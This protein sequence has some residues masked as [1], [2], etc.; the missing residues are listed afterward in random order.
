MKLTL[1]QKILAG[2]VA[3][4]AILITVAVFSFKNSEKYIDSAEWVNHT[5]Q[6]LIEF[7]QILINTVDA[8]TGARGYVI[9]GDESYLE[10][11]RTAEANV[12]EHLQNAKDLTKDNPKQQQNIEKLTTRINLRVEALKKCVTLR[13]ENFEAAQKFISSGEG[14]M[15]QDEIRKTIKEASDLEY[16]LLDERDKTSKS[17]I[18]NFNSLFIFLLLVI[19]LVLISVYIIIITNLRALKKAEDETAQKNWVLT[20]SGDLVKEMQG[21]KNVKELTQVVVEHLAQYLNAQVAAVYVTNEARD[22]LTLSGG[23]AMNMQHHDHPG[24]SYGQGLAG[25]AAAQ[26]KTIIVSDVAKELFTA[27]S[28]FG[29]IRPKTIIAV[30]FSYERSVVGVVELGNVT[31]FSEIQKQ[32]MEQ[33]ADSIAIAITSAQSREKTKELLEE[34]Q[35]QAE[36]LQAQQE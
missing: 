20:G 1:S 35:R 4:T 17:D 29:N 36:D 5:H 21:N 28:S 25:Q 6:V 3:C 31:H 9:T 26:N 14:K 24:F 11:Y 7:D 23:Y 34:T 15:L 22:K 16:V 12:Q 30:P 8:E 27:N 10:P 19:P 2:F 32:Y 13:K 33:V 18:N